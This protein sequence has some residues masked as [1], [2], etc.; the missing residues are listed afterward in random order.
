MINKALS[1]YDL[2]QEIKFSLNKLDLICL[3]A[4]VAS[5]TI[6]SSGHWYIILKDNVSQ[7]K[8]VMFKKRAMYSTEIKVGQTIQVFGTLDIY[9]A[10]GEIQFIIDSLRPIGVG[11]LYESF[12]V[13]KNKL[14][15]LGMFDAS[16]KKLIP[17]YIKT[18]GIITSLEAAALADVLKT[19]YLKVPF[20]KVL[21]YPCLVQGIQASNSIIKQI[22]LAN[23]QAKA[24][25]L[26]ICR[27]GG[28]IEDL[29]CYNDEYLAINIFNSNIPI[30]TGIGHE[31]DTSIADLVSSK[32]CA[33][34]TACVDE[35]GETIDIKKYKVQQYKNNFN[36]I[37]LSHI[38]NKAS[39]LLTY[40]NN[41]AKQNMLNIIN[42]KQR[43]LSIINC[44][45]IQ[46]IQNK[47]IL[48]KKQ[49]QK[50]YLLRSKLEQQINKSVKKANI[51]L[52]DDSGNYI[53]T[54]EQIKTNKNYKIFCNQNI[55]LIQFK[56]IIF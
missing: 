20:I 55:A 53:E 13:L 40:K 19:M 32:R 33:T 52:T 18:V 16:S 7:V 28:S 34:P 15:V 2:L 11:N 26:L 17:E 12:I 41:Y 9:D 37:L 10:R 24:D 22:E 43:K 36:S 51:Y 5:I 56:S 47:V 30:I 50:Y 46:S 42:Y 27:G 29:S 8:A 31:T 44:N 3:E 25:V 21:I 14:Q 49:Q 48:L 1:V 23:H 4:E 6:A 54:I 35:L 45:I 39:V 38:K